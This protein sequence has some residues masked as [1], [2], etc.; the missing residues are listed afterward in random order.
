MP[1]TPASRIAGENQA[2]RPNPSAGGMPEA[3][4][5]V[6]VRFRPLVGGIKF[7]KIGFP[8]FPATRFLPATMSVTTLE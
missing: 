2:G 3:N 5:S 1:S 4:R 6:I 8:A 7:E